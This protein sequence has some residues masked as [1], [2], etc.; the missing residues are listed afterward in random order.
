M[1]NLAPS[2]F[3][4]VVYSVARLAVSLPNMVNLAIF[5]A[6]GSR[7]KSGI[8]EFFGSFLAVFKISASSIYFLASWQYLALDVKTR[9]N[10]I[11]YTSPRG[12]A[13]MNFNMQATGKILINNWKE[14]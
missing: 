2:E 3:R 7:K 9:D 5:E 10:P 6:P 8:I 14:E 1:Y 13:I 12:T 4:E 11:R